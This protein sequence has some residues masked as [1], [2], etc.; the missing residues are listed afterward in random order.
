MI[1]IHLQIRPNQWT[2]ILFC[3]NTQFAKKVLFNQYINRIQS[4][5][6]HTSTF[7]FSINYYETNVLDL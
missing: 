5:K 1:E 2:F 4:T 3:K 6:K 7:S